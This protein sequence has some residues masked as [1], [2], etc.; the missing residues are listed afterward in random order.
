MNDQKGRKLLLVMRD[1]PLWPPA[2]ILNINL[3]LSTKTLHSAG[4]LLQYWAIQGC[5]M[6]RDDPALSF[7][8]STIGWWPVQWW[9]WG[10]L[11]GPRGI[12]IVQYKSVLLAQ[13]RFS[14]CCLLTALQCPV[15]FSRV[16]LAPTCRNMQ[17]LWML[18]EYIYLPLPLPFNL[19][20][21]AIDII[22]N[23]KWLAS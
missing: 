18:S 8:L 1:Y 5:Y 9:D 19:Y 12:L 15:G 16:Q 23:I 2:V 11:S 7:S 20:H 4:Y 10:V 13:L 3:H 22:C 14:V 17:P 21:I 6:Y